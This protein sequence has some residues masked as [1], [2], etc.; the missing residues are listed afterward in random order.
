[1]SSGTTT[2]IEA[3]P[4]PS[5]GRALLTSVLMAVLALSAC[6]T[7]PADPVARAEVELLN[8]PLEPL[9]R[10]V[11]AFNT[12]LRRAI[13]PLRKATAAGTSLALVW[14]G[15][16]N[17]LVNLRE[18]LVFA[19]D[20]AQGREC[21]AGASLR[22]FMVNTTLGAGGLFD[23]AKI[24]GVE[25]HDN[26]LGQT[27][28][29]WGVPAGPYLMLPG[30]GPS[31]LRGATG[32]AAEYIINPIDAGLVRA[33]AAA[34]VWPVAGLDVLDQN[35]D[36]APDLNKLERTSLDGYAALRSAYRQ[37]QDKVL[38][39]DNCP[40]V[41]RIPPLENSTARRTVDAQR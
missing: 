10:E 25:A 38:K 24:H 36:A 16:H 30:F 14:T 41:L 22:R 23:V 39:D 40:D 31:D 11:H 6:A 3:L 35:F 28:A 37:N 19:N 33:G 17:I 15:V 34:V 7:L 1:M 8:D 32:I 12:E 4:K 26:D 20:L 18:P 5:R 27:F 29:I 13:E 2:L 9:N 21:A